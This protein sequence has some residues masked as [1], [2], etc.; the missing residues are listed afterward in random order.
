[1]NSGWA[2]L[3][4]VA[5]S[6]AAVVGLF[7]GSFLNVVVYRIPLG[8]S[9]SRPR[10]FCPTC[11]RQLAWWEN[12]PLVSWL[13]L[14]GKCSTCHETI[15]GRYP[16]VEAITAATFAFVTWAWSGSLLASGYCVLAATSIAVALIEFGGKRSPLS[17]AASGLAL[18]E[19][20][21][22]AASLWLSEWTVLVGS[23]F[24]LVIGT[25]A[26]AL[27]RMRDPDCHARLCRGRSLLPVAGCWLGGLGARPAAAGIASVVVT[28]AACIAVAW[29]GR[30]R[31][32]ESGPRGQLHGRT[33]T[34]AQL[35]VS[36][37]T[38]IAILLALVVSLAVT[39]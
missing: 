35:I 24:G 27:S 16:L 4:W 9:V 12:V 1:L 26:F 17:V 32:E 25:T 15:S 34:L 30:H 36:V 8:L 29:Q 10:S 23:L 21:I 38:T 37:P 7:V 6:V 31:S 20:L 33:A 18:G 3:E 39:R 28:A 22:V 5:I 2:S 13:A 14:G 19:V 11:D